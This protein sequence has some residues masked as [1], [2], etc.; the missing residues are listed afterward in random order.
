[1]SLEPTAGLPQLQR[2]VRFHTGLRD[3]LLAFARDATSTQS[4]PDALRKMTTSAAD[5]LDAR[6]IEV[7]L[8]IAA[9]GS[10][11]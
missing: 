1:M 9:P 11:R 3:L 7:W 5:L 6:H 4:L 2:E 8:T 10:L